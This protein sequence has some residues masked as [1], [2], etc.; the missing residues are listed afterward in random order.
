MTGALGQIMMAVLSI[1]NCKIVRD[2]KWCGTGMVNWGVDENIG[3]SCWYCKGSRIPA[4]TVSYDDGFVMII[5]Y[6]GRRNYLLGGHWLCKDMFICK[7]ITKYHAN[8][9]CIY[10]CHHLSS[11]WTKLITMHGLF[12]FLLHQPAFSV[13]RS[14]CKCFVFSLNACTW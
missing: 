7:F 13:S 14:I 1:R 6:G 12:H 8:N 2:I 5:I 3:R 4:A 11:K 9:F 10:H